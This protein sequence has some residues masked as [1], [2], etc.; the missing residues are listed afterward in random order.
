[1][2]SV[3]SVEATPA[4]PAAITTGSYKYYVL[5]VLTV[6]SFFNYM[7][8]MVL[9][10]LVEPIKRDLNLSDT[11]IGLLSGFAFAALYATLG[12]PLA[13]LADTR[14]RTAIL[15]TCVAVWSAM[16]AACGLAGNFFH[17]LLARVGVGVGEAGCV[18]ASHSLLGDYFPAERRAFA[19]SVFQ[20]GGI[21]GISVGLMATGF[22]AEAFGWRMAFLLVG[23]PGLLLG[24][25]VMFTIRE[26]RSVA[27][28][29][30]AAADPTPRM[31]NLAAVRQLASR[32]AFVNLVAGL[33][34]GSFATYGLAQWLAA[35]FIR[36]H[37]L[38]LS[39]VGLWSGLSSGAGSVFGVLVGGVLAMHL[40]KRDRRWEL[41][42]PALSYGLG[43]PLY[44]GVFLWPD[45]WVAM[46]IKFLAGMVVASGGGVALAAIQSLA[47]PHLRATA[48]AVMMFFSSLIGLGAGPFFVGLISDQLQPTV[49]DQSLRY[50]LVTVTGILVFA[51]LHFYLASRTMRR[52]AVT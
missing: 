37:G 11:Q 40:I 35:F 29:R 3:H 12:I 26:P 14:S 49:G 36:V 27:Q 42:M 32:P 10:V 7:D 46:G 1:M 15:G 16:T 48:I 22:L 28:R 2:A 13:R 51:S 8:R 38:S 34:V 20:A 31:S 5:A 6:V 45:P 21:A 33:S 24:A 4:T 9:A 25:I 43:Y 19:I 47:E 50:A 23:A 41:W 18:P 39:E 30:A 17:M 44:M 52:D